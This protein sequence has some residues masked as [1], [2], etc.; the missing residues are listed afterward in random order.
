MS[1]NK[2]NKTLNWI[3]IIIGTLI[4]CFAGFNNKFPLL[5]TNSGNYINTGFIKETPFSG[6]FLYGLFVAH[7]SWGVSLWLVVITQTLILSVVISYYFKYFLNTEKYA[8][9]LLAFL[10]FITF[11]LSGSLS[12]STI[13]PEIFQI[14]TWL[15]TGLLLFKNLS[16]RDKNIV[17]LIFV[18][19]VSINIFQLT[20]ILLIVLAISILK[21]INC[22]YIVKTRQ[23]AWL[24]AL[25]IAAGLLVPSTSFIFGNGFNLFKNY[26]VTLLPGMVNSGLANDYIKKECVNSDKKLCLYKDS[27]DQIISGK[28]IFKEAYLCNEDVQEY[29]N[30][31]NDIVDDNYSLK[32]IKSVVTSEL[33][34]EIIA[35]KAGNDYITNDS[36]VTI[37]AVFDWYNNDVRELYISRQYNKNLDLKYINIGQIAF[38][39]IFL[40]LNVLIILF[41]KNRLHRH[42]SLYFLAVYI[43]Q[44]LSTTLF[45]GPAHIQYH[46]VWMLSLPVFLY[47]LNHKHLEISTKN[48]K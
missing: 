4:L 43:M 18:L 47:F 22:R 1:I 30:A 14:T 16:K 38:L 5:S 24:G 32:K 27:L 28:G 45:Y 11:L 34:T 48:L 17:S 2:S 20:G 31:V 39:I 7:A 33:W 15:C 9:Y 21:I 25:I 40:V 46:F 26:K 35:V 10:F 36:I 3:I 41:C 12:S 29:E 19:S 13:S 6:S 44:A 37:K 23:L 42:L 8:Y